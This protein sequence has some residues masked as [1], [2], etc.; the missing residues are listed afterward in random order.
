MT[1]KQVIERLVEIR[2][3]NKI[4][5]KSLAK[6]IG[7]TTANLSLLERGKT[8]LSVRRFLQICDILCVEPNKILEEEHKQSTLQEIVMEMLN[9][10]P[11]EEMELLVGVARLLSDRHDL[12][13]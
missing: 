4:T 8:V 7:I 9:N 3:Q 6:E 1:E 10:L 13:P 2:K 12:R 11:P 5:Q